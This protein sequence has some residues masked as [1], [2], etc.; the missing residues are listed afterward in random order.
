MDPS[1]VF[2]VAFVRG[3]AVDRGEQAARIGEHDAR[4]WLLENGP[5]IECLLEGTL[6]YELSSLIPAQEDSIVSEGS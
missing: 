2:S 6:H 4:P 5:A 1:E 3:H